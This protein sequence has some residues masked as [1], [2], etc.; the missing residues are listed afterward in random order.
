MEQNETSFIELVE[1]QT[2]KNVKLTNNSID[3]LKNQ[4]KY[5]G[6]GESEKLHNDLIKGIESPQNDFKIQTTS[7]K[8]MKGN[9]IEFDLNFRKT[10]QG[11]VF[12]NS[13]DA[14]LSTQQGEERT[15]TFKVQ[16]ENGVTAKEAIN[17]LEGR[18]VKLNL[19]KVDEDT[20]EIV[21]EAVFVKFKLN[22][23]TDYGNY[24]L[25]G[26]NADKYG[27]DVYDIMEKS[28][29]IFNDDLEKEKVKKS[30]EKGNIT[31]V[32][33]LNE[34]KHQMKAFAVLNP[35]W[36][37]LNLYDNNMARI[38]STKP[39]QKNTEQNNQNNIKE[40]QISR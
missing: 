15:H 39:I 4:L 26:Y 35:Q 13:Y 10:E 38:N 23:K 28:N 11:G 40:H 32:N 16:K 9:T 30:L 1:Q 27:I 14:K 22:E 18:A 37:M 31:S 6:F 17:L 24:K 34:K 29:L 33:I 21:K 25:D 7:D 12:F 2:N 36:K 5:L 8:V 20:G 19:G 3:Y